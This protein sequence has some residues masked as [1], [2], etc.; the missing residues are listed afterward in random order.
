[1]ARTNESRLWHPFAEMGAVRGAEV[2]IE[3]GDD[4]WVFDVGGR[5][6]LDATASL[7]YANVGHGRTEIARA[8]A[9]QLKR[10]E[11]YSVFGEF[12]TPPALVLAERLSGLAPM[13]DARIFLGT[14]GGDAIETAVK[15]ARRFW[16]LSGQPERM[17]LVTRSG[18]Y[19]GM[20]GFGTALAGIPANK[21]GMGPLTSGVSVVPRDSVEALEAEFYRLGPERVAAVFVEPVLGAGGV[22]PPVPGYLEGVAALCREVGV[23]LIVD[24]VICGFGR[25]GTWFGI[26]RWGVQPDMICFAKGVTSGYLPLGGLVVAD[27]VAKPFWTDDAPA[28]RHGTTYS[29]HA[30]CCA[31]AL[32]NLDIL[33][34]DGLLAR[35]QLLEQDLLSALVPLS[36]F[37]AVAEVRGGTGLLAA[38]ELD[39]ALLE[40]DPKASQ[41]VASLARE[42]GVIVR[43]LATSIAVS[44]PL[45][46][47]PAH[48]ALIGAALASSLASIE[49][50]SVLSADPALAGS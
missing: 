44:P 7:W 27:R 10:I 17:A 38:V 31:A 22:H 2:I 21:E 23:L 13:A 4:V 3:R 49:A 48:F 28:F 41:R 26:E 33:E 42:A 12:A 18:S 39:P 5:R 40:Q 15:L 11:T 16:S 50:E 46:A 14:G 43:P 19:H 36:R 47:T 20:H 29:G 9:D 6:L 8:I 37:P 34:R 32:A 24:A 30:V 35:G 45:T 1:M 25:L